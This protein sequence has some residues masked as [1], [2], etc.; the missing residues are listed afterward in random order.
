MA[1][2]LRG[3]QRSPRKPIRATFALSLLLFLLRGIERICFH[4]SRHEKMNRRQKQFTVRNSNLTV[5]LGGRNKNRDTHGKTVR[6]GR[7]ALAE[8]KPKC[9]DYLSASL[10]LYYQIKFSQA[11]AAVKKISGEYF[12]SELISTQVFA[13]F[14]NHIKIKKTLVQSNPFDGLKISPRSSQ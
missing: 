10:S 13:S 12:Q 8:P 2:I 6:L 3:V 11:K 1:E 14:L 5:R 9:F 4:S 7:S